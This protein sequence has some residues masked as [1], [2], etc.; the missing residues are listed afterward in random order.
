M[1]ESVFQG[2][3]IKAAYQGSHIKAVMPVCVQGLPVLLQ[4]L[5]VFSDHSPPLPRL[6]PPSLLLPKDNRQTLMLVLSASATQAICGALLTPRV[7]LVDMIPH[8]FQYKFTFLR[9]SIQ[10]AD[11]C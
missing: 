1:L 8:M 2:S 7:F 9:V 5:T 11:H 10:Y 3:H 4:H 6:M